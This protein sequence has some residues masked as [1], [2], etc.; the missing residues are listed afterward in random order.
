M[1]SIK[2]TQKRLKEVI[3]YNKLT[4]VFIWRSR[5]ISDFSN[6]KN[7]YGTMISYNT[8]L[9]G[10]EAG[11]ISKSSRYIVIGVDGIK[12]QAHRLVWLYEYGFMPETGLDHINRVRDDNRLLNLREAGKQCNSRN[13]KVQSNN[14]SGIKGVSYDTRRKSWRTYI[15]T[16]SKNIHIG[17]YQE[18]SWAVKARWQAE[19]KYN[20]PNCNTTSSAYEY[21]KEHNLLDINENTS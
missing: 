20:F 16:N 7:P 6:C 18:L 4:G 21:L 9:A 17:Y 5:S 8:R 15:N 11:H 12:Y 19:V 2:L 10:M 3:L 1:N 13:S 14:T